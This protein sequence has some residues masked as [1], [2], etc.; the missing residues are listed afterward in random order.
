[1]LGFGCI[2]DNLAGD[3]A[4]GEAQLTV[5]V[6][7]PGG[8]QVLFSFSNSGPAASSITDVYFDDGSLLELAVVIN[9]LVLPGI[10]DFSQDASPGDL[11]AG[12][13]ADPDFN[14]T[15]GFNADSSPPTQP[16][17]VNPGELLGILF[18][19]QPG[20]DFNDVLAEL[21]DGTLRI[22][23]HVQGYTSGG[24]ESLI[25]HPLPEPALFGLLSLGAGALLCARA[26]RS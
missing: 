15:A 7:D 13:N 18:T 9:D 4:I 14:T 5:D 23:I 20:Q 24:S 19:L 21:G 17:G 10:V 6:T 1:M 3:C 11:P 22:G 12:N 25:N 16:N 8:G 2:S 26:R